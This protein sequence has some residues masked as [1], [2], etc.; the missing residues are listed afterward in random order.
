[1]LITQA[2]NTFTFVVNEKPEKAGIDPFALLVDREPKD[3]LK[4][5]DN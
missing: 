3:N 5:C 1:V 2:N 4:K